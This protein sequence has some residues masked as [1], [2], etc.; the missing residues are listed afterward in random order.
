M[1]YVRL[2]PILIFTIFGSLQ[3]NVEK[4]V[5]A[6]T[7]SYFLGALGGYLGLFL[8]GSILGFFDSIESFVKKQSCNAV[9]IQ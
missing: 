5:Y 4:Q 8:G 6:Y 7:T 1:R 3:V 2:E 9:K